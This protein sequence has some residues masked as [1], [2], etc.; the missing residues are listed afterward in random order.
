MTRRNRPHFR[1]SARRVIGRTGQPVTIIRQS[2]F[3]RRGGEPV[4]GDPTTESHTATVLPLRGGTHQGGDARSALPEGARLDQGRLFLI[5]LLPGHQVAAIRTVHDKSG[6][7]LICFQGVDYRVYNV[8]D[9][10]DF[11]HIEVVALGP[12]RDRAD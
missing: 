5:H 11:G 1:R 2:E 10:A 12:D 4:A 6:P 7:D 9:Y 3:E 8:E